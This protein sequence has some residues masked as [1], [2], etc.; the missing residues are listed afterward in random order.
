[1]LKNMEHFDLKLFWAYQIWILVHM[2]GIN[3]EEQF[4]QID[5]VNTQLLH[6]ICDLP[7]LF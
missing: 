7:K 3:V 4:Q 5:C 2:Q 6:E 1:M